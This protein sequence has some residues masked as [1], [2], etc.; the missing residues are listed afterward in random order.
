[1]NVEVES[2]DNE[3]LENGS[4]KLKNT[5]KI[6]QIRENHRPMKINK[7]LMMLKK[8]KRKTLTNCCELLR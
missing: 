2:A 6:N 4:W 8:E 1:M 3:N 5:G 7:Q